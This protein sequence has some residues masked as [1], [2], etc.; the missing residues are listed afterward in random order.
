[1]YLEHF[2]LSAEP[3]SIAPDPEF[4]FLSNKHN[5]ALSHLLYGLSNGGF[6]LLTGE[7]GTGKTTLLRSLL[8]T[9]PPETNIAFIL[10]PRLTV[11]ELLET[12]C[13]EFGIELKEKITPTV[14]NYIDVLNKF[15]SEN[16]DADQSAVLIIDEAQNL[17]TSVMEQIR[18]LTNIET[19]NKKLLQ[20][21]LIGQPELEEKL[22]RKELRQLTQRITARYRLE[23]LTKK[24]TK[25]YIEHRLA[26]VGKSTRIFKSSAVATIFRATQGIPRLINLLCDRA[27]LGAYSLDLSEI[28]SS[29]IRQSKKEVFGVQ[30]KKTNHSLTLYLLPFAALVLFPVWFFLYDTAEDTTHSAL[31]SLMPS[32]TQANINGLQEISDRS[33]TKYRSWKNYKQDNTFAD[34]TKTRSLAFTKLYAIWGYRHGNTPSKPPCE[35]A[36]QFGLECLKGR[37]TWKDISNLNIPVILEL[38]VD[39]DKPQYALLEEE[40]ASG[41]FLNINSEKLI[42]NKIDLNNSWFGS[43]ET[44]WQPPPNYENPLSL[45]AKH[46]S[47]AWLKKLLANNLDYSFDPD[48]LTL[49]NQKLLTFIEEFQRQQGLIV[50]GVIG[51]LTWIKLSEY[52]NISSPTLK[53]TS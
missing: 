13:D 3:F 35:L 36:S 42:I 47:I 28:D 30:S 24:E 11:I 43:Y 18:L 9:I 27:M 19:D 40:T 50:D 25:T 4:L 16:N 20:I 52:L 41:Y 14:K 38:W 49:Y 1:M 48:Q 31:N 32:A 33:T 26:K 39:F 5:E 6:V 37:G 7:V 2:K 15:L 21:V 46:Q 44:L 53:A 51:P 45:G 17:S 29:L 8:K 22:S 12:I 34:T 23:A 10:N